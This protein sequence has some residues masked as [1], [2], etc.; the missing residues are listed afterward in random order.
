MTKKLLLLAALLL[1]LH[2]FSEHCWM[3]SSCVGRIGF[4]VVAESHY[5]YVDGDR[6]N[7]NGKP[8]VVNASRKVFR[9]DG[10]PIV[11]GYY[12]LNGSYYELL[13]FHTNA[14]HKEKVT[15]WFKVNDDYRVRWNKEETEAI[16][17]VN[18]T[19]FGAG[20]QLQSGTVIKVKRA[21]LLQKEIPSISKEHLLL[22]V[23][24]LSEPDI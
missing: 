12:T 13:S 20:D 11:G 16:L 8:Y 23:E 22:M 10:Y 5:K 19:Q 15:N 4:L 17:Q 6:G 3:V 14:T 1:P 2:S 24:V 7:L 9:E 21:E 18:I